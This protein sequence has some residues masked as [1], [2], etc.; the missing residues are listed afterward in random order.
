MTRTTDINVTHG[1]KGTALTEVGY[2][3]GRSKSSATPGNRI[4]FR[5]STDYR[6]RA[7]DNSRVGIVWKACS[8]MWGTGNLAVF[9]A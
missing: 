8:N 4:G 3:R 7:G 2:T 1:L 9:L 6:T 5:L